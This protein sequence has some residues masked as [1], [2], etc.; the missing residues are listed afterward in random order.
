MF[1]LLINLQISQSF[2]LKYF[3]IFLMV[4]YFLRGAHHIVGILFAGKFGFFAVRWRL[5]RKRRKSCSIANPRGRV[6]HRFSWCFSIECWSYSESNKRIVFIFYFWNKKKIFCL[7]CP[8]RSLLKFSWNM[9]DFV[10][11]TYLAWHSFEQTAFLLKILLVL[12]KYFS[13]HSNKQHKILL[14]QYQWDCLYEF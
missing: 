6:F 8:L 10:S 7:T 3:N 14:F 9:Q 4:L 12:S 1:F 11:S 5:L 13:K 2:F